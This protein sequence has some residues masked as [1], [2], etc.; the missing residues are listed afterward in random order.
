MQP[1]CPVTRRGP[2][3]RSRPGTEEA[4]RPKIVCRVVI[5]MLGQERAGTA[6]DGLVIV[7]IERRADPVEIGHA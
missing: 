1:A 3:A 5:G 7:A 6:Q 2:R 4:R